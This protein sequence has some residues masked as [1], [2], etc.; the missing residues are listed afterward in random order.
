MDK[1]IL[2]V[3]GE[4][5]LSVEHISCTKVTKALTLNKNETKFK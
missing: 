3:K 5:S 4:A 2:K 1:N